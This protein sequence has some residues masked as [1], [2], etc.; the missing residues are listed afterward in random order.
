MLRNIPAACD[1]SFTATWLAGR[2]PAFSSTVPEMIPS[3]RSEVEACAFVVG[4]HTNAVMVTKRMERNPAIKR[5]FLAFC[6]LHSISTC[7][8]LLRCSLG[9][10]GGCRGQSVTAANNHFQQS[11]SGCGC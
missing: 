6:N 3:V 9:R 7:C 5:N 8:A 11:L 4:A 1:F 10:L 2:L